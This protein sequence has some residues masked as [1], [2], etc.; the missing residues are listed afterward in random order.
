MKRNV[1]MVGWLLAAPLALASSGKL[2]ILVDDSTEMPLASLRGNTLLAGIH[3]DLGL[4]LARQLGQQASFRVLPRKR[5]S[6]SLQNGEADLI[7]LYMPEWLPGPF[8]WSKPFISNADVVVTYRDQPRPGSITELAG[9]SIGTV[10]GFRYPELEA[11]LGN[12]LVRDD[13]PNSSSNLKKLEAGRIHHAVVN[14][15]YLHYQQKLGQLPLALHPP[16]QLNSYRAGCALSPHSQVSLPQLNRAIG[17]LL[18]DHT[19]PR[20]LAKYR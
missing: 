17:K 5:I 11:Q 2:Q 6:I 20:I 14:Q 3:F 4:A 12:Q 16:L 8:R 13:A 1:M 18:N 19:L 15:L 10:H 7:C 9:H